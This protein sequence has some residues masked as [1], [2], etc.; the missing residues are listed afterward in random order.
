MFIFISV[1]GLYKSYKNKE[2]YFGYYF[3]KRV[4]PLILAYVITSLIYYL[5]KGIPSSY[6]WYIAAISY[7]YIIFYIA[8]KRNNNE[9]LSLLIVLLATLIYCVFCKFMMFGGWCYNVIGLFLV[10]ILFAKFEKYVIKVLK[11]AYIPLLLVT[12]ILM[13]VFRYYGK[14]YE[15]IIY[16]VTKESIYDKYSFLIILYRFLAALFFVLTVIL[17]SLKCKFNNKILSF[18]DSISLEFYLIQGLF[19]HAFSYSYFDA[20]KPIYY[21]KNIPLY[22]LVVFILAS[23][24]AFIIN[25]VDKKI[26]Q[27]WNY[28][29]RREEYELAYV[30]KK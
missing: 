18:Y 9:Y 24:S 5:Y 11:K 7:C 15:T 16:N 12:L 2:N 21:I 14:H 29:K 25:F 30:K 19:V 27:F 23:I 6:T 10:G 4:F 13:I 20:V 1:Y 8:F 22:I 17:V 28:F 26:V 3:S